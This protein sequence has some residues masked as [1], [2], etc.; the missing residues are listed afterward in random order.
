MHRA[1]L[2]KIRKGRAAARLSLTLDQVRPPVTRPL[3]PLQGALVVVGGIVSVSEVIRDVAEQSLLKGMM[4]IMGR[5]LD[6][7]VALCI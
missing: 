1:V 4:D 6:C 3:K 7:L 2:S 5:L